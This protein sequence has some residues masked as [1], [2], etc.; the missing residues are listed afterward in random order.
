LQSDNVDNHNNDYNDIKNIDSDN[1]KFKL[2]RYII[3]L[4]VFVSIS[5]LTLIYIYQIFE[6][7]ADI[8]I[9]K[10]LPISILGSLLLLLFI[11]FIFDGFRLY[12]VLRT[13]D[14]HIEFKYIFKLVFIN[15]FISNITPFATG[16]GFIQIYYLTKKDISLGNATAATTIRTI[17]ATVIVFI[18]T[19]IIIINEK[20][21]ET[22]LP[23]QSLFIYMTLFAIVYIL[24]FYIVIFKNRVLKKYIYIFLTFIRDKNIISGKKF[25]KTSKYLFEEIDIFGSSLIYFFT[26]DK[27]FII[28]SIIS[29]VLFLVAELSF[30]VLLLTGLGYN[31]SILRIILMQV[32]VIFF[33]YFAPTPGATGIAE[34]GYSLVFS[35][36]V[37]ESDMFPLI[38]AW[39]LLTKYI[40]IVIGM[41]IFFITFVR[42]GNS[43]E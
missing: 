18:A 31:L 8:L 36:F 13:L 17:L 12:F 37:Q 32:I 27:K 35:Q 4:V 19:P 14:C 3:Y 25:K 24:F 15:L 10:K 41:F 11:Y 7:P 33:M 26:G 21:F 6:K 9:F 23:Q 22:I 1:N 20:S 40:G 43:S 34:G 29:S 39:R 2:A 16:G 38:F 28:S 5:V 42:E 30:S